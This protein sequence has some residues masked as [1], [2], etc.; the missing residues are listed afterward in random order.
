MP[1]LLRAPLPVLVAAV[2]VVA[3]S[4]LL[5]A[6]LA[7]GNG[8]EWARVWVAAAAGALSA[9]LVVRLLVLLA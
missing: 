5:P 2:A 3:A 4:A 7:R 9:S 1:R 6:L 8:S